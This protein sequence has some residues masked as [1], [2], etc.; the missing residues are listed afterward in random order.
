MQEKLAGLTSGSFET[1]Q[2]SCSDTWH[3]RGGKIMSYIESIS[4]HWRKLAGGAGIAFLLSFLVFTVLPKTYESRFSLLPVDESERGLAFDVANLGALAGLGGSLNGQLSPFDRLALILKSEDFRWAVLRADDFRIL[5]KIIKI[6][7]GVKSS[8]MERAIRPGALRVFSGVISVSKLSKG[9]LVVKVMFNNPDEAAEIAQAVLDQLTIH[10]ASNSITVARRKGDFI[11]QLLGAK[12]KELRTIQEQLL[13]FGVSGEVLGLSD[14]ARARYSELSELS[15]KIA[16]N[17][18]NLWVVQEYQPENAPLAAKLAEE[19]ARLEGAAKNIDLEGALSS[20]R[21][22]VTVP[23][24]RVPLLKITL[25]ALQLQE[26]LTTE[27]IG[28]LSRE[29]EMARIA[30]VSESSA[31]QVIDSPKISDTPVGIA[32]WRLALVFSLI[33]CVG[34]MVFLNRAKLLAL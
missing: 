27:V 33:I 4:R 6:P 18:V 10:L 16:M 21:E 5:H 20:S 2:G 28:L 29:Y 3:K 19:V 34:G 30:E 13:S 31:F 1:I 17:K 11:E 15:K 32:P 22:W 25:S 23:I 7:A 26:R 9:P 8:D 12:R 24:S 14:R